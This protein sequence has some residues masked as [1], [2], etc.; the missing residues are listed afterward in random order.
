[1]AH[2]SG[3]GEVSRVYNPEFQKPEFSGFSVFQ[4]ARHWSYFK[5]TKLKFFI[6]WKQIKSNS[7][8]LGQFLNFRAKNISIT[9]LAWKF[10]YRAKCFFNSEKNEF[11]ESG[12]KYQ[13]INPSRNSGVFATLTSTSSS[14]NKAPL[15]NQ[16]ASSSQVLAFEEQSL[17]R[18]YWIHYYK[19]YV[20]P[21]GHRCCHCYKLYNE[22]Y[23]SGR[24]Q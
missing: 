20:V 23:N 5:S 8:S 19:W 12:W 13:T 16:W 2:G 4:F 7:K 17:L 15:M 1:M 3:R 22:G 10:T 9:L 21:V 6:A 24:G 18:A 11:H 14:S